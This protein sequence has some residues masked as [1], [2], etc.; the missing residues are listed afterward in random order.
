MENPFPLFLSTFPKERDRELK[1][2]ERHRVGHFPG[3]ESA[4]VFYST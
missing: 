4:L 2:F 3:L 1:P